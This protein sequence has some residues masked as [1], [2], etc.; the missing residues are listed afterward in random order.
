MLYKYPPIPCAS[1]L[2][3]ILENSSTISNPMPEYKEQVYNTIL[4]PVDRSEAQLFAEQYKREPTDT[5][6]LISGYL[7]Y[8]GINKNCSGEEVDKYLF[9]TLVFSKENMKNQLKLNW[10]A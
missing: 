9:K 6:K 5:N 7:Q 10:M 3:G 4:F 2:I 1:I 8:K